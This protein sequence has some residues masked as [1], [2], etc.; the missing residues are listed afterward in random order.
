MLTP[1]AFP[2]VWLRYVDDVFAVVKERHLNQLLQL[3][4]SQH[5]TI[6]FTVEKE[7]NGSLPFLDLRVSRSE[8][9]SL[10]FSIYRK[11]THTDRFITTD[12]YHN[13]SNKKAAF[14]SM[15]HRLYNIPMSKQ[16][17]NEEKQYIIDTAAK[18]GYSRK[19]IDK[20]FNQHHQ[21]KRFREKTTL[22]PVNEPKY[23]ISVPYCPPFTNQLG[24]KLR[25]HNIEL[26]T[27]TTSTLKSQLCNYKDKQ[28]PQ[29]SSGI[30]SIGCNNCDNIYIGQTSR[31]IETRVKEHI[32]YTKNGDRDK[33]GVAEHMHQHQHTID[34]NNIKGVKTV[35]SNYHLDAFESQYIAN[36]DVPLMN[37]DD[38]PIVS[39]IFYLS[40]LSYQL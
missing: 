9:N 5:E 14:H 12:S 23:R 11:P 30:Y 16:A 29:Q 4:N 40:S 39:P 38:P 1:D 6:E 21:K 13:G 15:A 27:S 37:I 8:D 18:N 32:R 17:F 35:R 22:E 31:R 3:I 28:S 24:A 10:S 34:T 20:I 36:S 2:R 26:V 33:S 25:R 19:F 7:V